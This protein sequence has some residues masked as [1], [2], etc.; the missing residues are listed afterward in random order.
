MR[1]IAIVVVVNLI[2]VALIIYDLLL[3]LAICT[4]DHVSTFGQGKQLE[5]DGVRGWN[6]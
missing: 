1:C 4:R 3:I 6:E 2:L 5:L